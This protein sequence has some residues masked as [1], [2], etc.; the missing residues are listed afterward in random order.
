[1]PV[2]LTPHSEAWF[3][4]LQKF[5]PRQAEM[6]RVVINAAGRMD[7]CSTC[8]DQRAAVYK[9][10]DPSLEDDAV[11]TIRLCNDCKIIQDGNFQ[12]RTK[13]SLVL[14]SVAY[15]IADTVVQR[16]YHAD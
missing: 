6:T 14:G 11:A 15:K 1:M 4:A 7:V 9:L 12:L 13:T 10:V 5:N 3:E 2:Y 8:G 16:K